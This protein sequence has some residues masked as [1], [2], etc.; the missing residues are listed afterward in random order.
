MT[1]DTTTQSAPHAAAAADVPSE[2]S[3]DEGSAR[4]VDGCSARE[5][6][7]R[8]DAVWEGIEREF[9]GA[10]SE[11]HTNRSSSPLVARPSDATLRTSDSLH[12]ER[13]DGDVSGATRQPERRAIQSTATATAMLER[14]RR[15]L[16]R[17]SS[18][19][20]VVEH[21]MERCILYGLLFRSDRAGGGGGGGGGARAELYYATWNTLRWA[22]DVVLAGR[23]TGLTV[24]RVDELLRPAPV[25]AP[26]DPARDG[27]GA[28]GGISD[29]APP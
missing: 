23:G 27:D 6:D 29:R 11:V 2:E 25:R 19:L 22:N 15:F 21:V 8:L 13:F 28:G 4:S 12:I 14:Y 16:R 26:V 3:A 9:E 10:R 7:E 18:S 24:G 20:D 17:H 5:E 1:E